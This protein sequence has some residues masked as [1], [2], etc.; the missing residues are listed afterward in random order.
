MKDFIFFR[1]VV[2]TFT[3]LDKSIELIFAALWWTIKPPP[4]SFWSA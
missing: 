2:P 4:E 1:V 3:V